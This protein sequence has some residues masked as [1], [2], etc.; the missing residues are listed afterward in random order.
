L[1]WSKEYGGYLPGFYI[2]LHTF[3]SAL[4]FNPHLHVLITAGGLALDRR[5]W[6]EA[7]SDYLM[8]EKGLKKRWRYNV[9]SGLIKADQAGRL[10]MPILTKS[11]AALN[12]R[13][14]IAVI[15]K[16]GWYVFIGA[17]LAQVGLTVKYIGRYTKKPVI[18]EARIIRCDGRWI[19]FKF[20][21]YAEGGKS[22][23]K[24]MGLFKFITF[25]TQHIHDKHF[26]VVRGYG[27]FS[28]RLKGQLLPEARVL[29]RQTPRRKPNALKTWRERTMA[30]TKK[31]PLI[32]ER[33]RLEMVLV[34]VCFRPDPH[35]LEKLK[36]DPYEKIPSRQMKLQPDG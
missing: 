19:V 31:D 22:A 27:L 5:K 10:A 3:G 28:N 26:R 24:K 21:D 35:W 2:V 14:V 18:A 8:P 16:A 36:L 30:R 32:C 25:L 12:L 33:C 20:K 15:A 29:L 6:L 13:G 1:S 34:F 11:G 7:P 23:V 17:R 4:I 9:I